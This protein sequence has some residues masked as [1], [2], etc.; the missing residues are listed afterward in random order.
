MRNNDISNKVAPTVLFDLDLLLEKEEK[1]YKGIGEMLV[2]LFNPPKEEY[3]I[4]RVMRDKLIRIWNTFDV[5]IGLFTFDLDWELD[6]EKLHRLLFKYYVP[7][8]RIV[9]CVDEM[10]L[11]KERFLYIF[12]DKEDLL[13]VL[14]DVK[15]LHI[16]KLPEVLK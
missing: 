14:S 8:N 7:Y 2:S 4:N 3:E 11:R 13:S 10:D 16:E 15:A 6:E 5:Q 1:R 12:T 9:Y